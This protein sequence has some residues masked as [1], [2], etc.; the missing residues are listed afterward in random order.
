LFQKPS[1]SDAIPERF[2]IGIFHD[3]EISTPFLRINF[4]NKRINFPE[5]VKSLYMG[6]CAVIAD[7]FRFFMLQEVTKNGFR[8]SSPPP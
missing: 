7:L 2:F 3:A 8:F 1:R 5:N 4:W 6:V